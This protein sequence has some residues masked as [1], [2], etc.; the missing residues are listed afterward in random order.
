MKRRSFLAMLGLAP[1]A[2]TQAVKAAA[3]APSGLWATGGYTG[4]EPARI[5]W[6]EGVVQA[7]W[8]TTRTIHAGAVTSE[9][10]EP[11]VTWTLRGVNGRWYRVTLTRPRVYHTVSRDAQGRLRSRVIEMAGDIDHEVHTALKGYPLR[12]F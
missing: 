2:A 6:D 11:D 3:A 10:F 1:I 9:M 8:I 7:D 4:L 5:I 12:Q